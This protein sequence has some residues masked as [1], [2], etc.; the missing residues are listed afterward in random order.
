MNINL[1]NE[2][3]RHWI[4]NSRY[5]SIKSYDKFIKYFFPDTVNVSIDNN[6]FKYC[7]LNLNTS[8]N[9]ITYKD[10]I[11][12]I[13]I[14]VENCYAHYYELYYKYGMFG[15]K[16]IKI[17]F[18]NHIDKII[19]TD[20][21]IAIPIIYNQIDYFNKYY[22]DIKP[23]IITQ[24]K[25]K[26]FCLFVSNNRFRSDIKGKIKDFLQSINHCDTI[27]IYK[28]QLSNK[29]CYHSI[30]LMNVFNQYNF[31][32]ACENSLSDGYITEKI[33]NCFFSRTIPIYNGCESIND[34]FNKNS[35][36]NTN[37]INNLHTLRDN[38]TKLMNDEN[39]YNKVINYDKINKLYNNE[40]YKMKFKD[41]VNILEDRKDIKAYNNNNIINH[42]KKINNQ[43]FKQEIPRQE[44]LKQE[45][46]K[47]EKIK[48]ERL[49]Q[50]RLKQEIPK[51]S[52]PKQE[53][54]KQKKIKQEKLKQEKLKQE[55]L[56]QEK[57]KQDTKKKK[58]FKL[59][60]HN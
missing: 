39:L 33:F 36:I 16:N 41:F 18:Y 40:N 2:A 47:Q 31:I 30:E 45:R 56:K 46:L 12:Y 60:N 49:K 7:I 29:S 15:N 9:D 3:D 22:N 42:V 44:R 54:T 58:K 20:E 17:F 4:T 5:S 51:Q 26:K 53:I 1:S 14:C 13:L 32:F 57:L 8:S 27:D 59:F 25:D 52:K 55:K 43:R 35:F 24:F 34:Y 10:N 23:I 19:Q 50:E 48:Q 28:P 21:Y 37:D 6:N 38:I 11:I